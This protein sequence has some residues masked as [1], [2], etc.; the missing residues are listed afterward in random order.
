LLSCCGGPRHV[1]PQRPPVLAL[2]P[3]LVSAGRSVCSRDSGAVLPKAVR[4]SVAF[5][6]MV[7]TLPWGR[8]RLSPA[9]SG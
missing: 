7:A 8:V 3:S 6:P 4:D 2:L 1:C 5:E 9:C